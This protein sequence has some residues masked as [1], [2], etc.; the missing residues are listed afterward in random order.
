MSWDV[1]VF[2]FDGKP[3][4][5]ILGLPDD[6]EI[7]EIGASDVVRKAIS[8]GFPATDW[9]DTGWGVVDGD[10]W[11]IEFNIGQ[12]A[13]VGQMMIWHV[14]GSGDPVTPIA[15]LCKAQGW[16]PLDS[17]DSQFLDLDAPSTEGWEHFQAFRDQILAKGGTFSDP[18]G[19]DSGYNALLK[20]GLDVG[21]FIWFGFLIVAGIYV[22]R[23]F[24]RTQSG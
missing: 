7:P 18:M 4:A 1:I 22:A 24:S 13:E 5:N 8:S 9:S 3:P 12:E 17:V 21:I 6:Y 11:S 16:S 20:T 15:A 19:M 2:D 10:G 14:R 23:R